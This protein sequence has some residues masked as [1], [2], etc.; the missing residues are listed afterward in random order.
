M[1]VLCVSG[2][3]AGDSGAVRG[4]SADVPA[5]AGGLGLADDA[6]RDAYP[7]DALGKSGRAR[8]RLRRAAG[9]PDDLAHARGVDAV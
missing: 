8:R 4:E 7:G 1:A 5:G 3:G 2:A 6:G 9:V